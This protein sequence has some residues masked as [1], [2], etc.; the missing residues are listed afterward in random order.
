M[1]NFLEAVGPWP[2]CKDKLG[3]TRFLSP[4]LTTASIGTGPKEFKVVGLL[5]GLESLIKLHYAFSILHF[6]SLFISGEVLMH[7]FFKPQ[8][9]LL[10]SLPIEKADLRVFCSHQGLDQV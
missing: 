5:L 1:K 4:F 2:A 8:E 7:S 6:K 9:H 10:T 3:P